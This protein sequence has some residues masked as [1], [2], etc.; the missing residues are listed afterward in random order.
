LGLR[1]DLRLRK[2]SDFDA[3][4]QR[5]RAWH[6]HLLVLRT[7]PNKL[8]HNR[9]GLVTT[10]RLGGAVVRNRTRRRLREILRETPARQGFDLVV[11]AKRPAA[12]ASFQDLRA[13]VSR[14]Y[15]RGGLTPEEA[16]HG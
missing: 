2:R 9:Y 10:K 7:L 3:V 4:F 14:L 8:D 11:S 5:G 16:V 6:N 15:A 1:R 13:S 12:A